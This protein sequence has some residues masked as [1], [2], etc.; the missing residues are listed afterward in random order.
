M[1]A[2]IFHMNHDI[3]R[4]GK[5]SSSVGVP[6]RIAVRYSKKEN[7]AMTQQ[8]STEMPVP[9]FKLKWL[10]HLTLF[11]NSTLFLILVI[12]EVLQMLVELSGFFLQMKTSFYLDSSPNKL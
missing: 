8:T 5:N 3:K 7:K 9:L 11:W 2:I 6:N 4:V 10:Y 1:N 12:K